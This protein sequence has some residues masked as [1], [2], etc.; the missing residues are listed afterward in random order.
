MAERSMCKLIPGLLLNIS[1]ALLLQLAMICATAAQTGPAVAPLGWRTYVIPEFGTR[2][3]YPAGILA[4]A[5][6]PKTGTGETFESQ[7][8]RAVLS[9]YAR[10]NTAGES[11]ASYLRNNLRV[12]PTGL[13]Y[14]RITR[15]FFAI[16]MERAGV[17]HYSRCNFS[18]TNGGAT[19]C[20]DLTYPQEDKRVWDPVVTRISL[21]LQPKE[22]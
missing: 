19:H 8:G 2:I 14:Q 3:D 12:P 15:S 4:P 5:G 1:A 21:S 18:G 6:A 11:P 17:I 22:R 7:D 9:V 20:F 13:D 16:S 10:E